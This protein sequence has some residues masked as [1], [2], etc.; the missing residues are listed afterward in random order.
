MKIGALIRKLRIKAELT[1]EQLALEIGKEQSSISNWELGVY[2]PSARSLI[3]LSEELKVDLIVL[4]DAIP[5]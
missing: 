1:Q 2:V 5:R 4:V 3:A